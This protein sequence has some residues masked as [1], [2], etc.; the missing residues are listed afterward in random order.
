MKGATIAPS[1][2]ETLDIL[3]NRLKIFSARW[4]PSGFRRCPLAWAIANAAQPTD[5]HL[6]STG[7]GTVAMLALCLPKPHRCWGGSLCQRCLAQRNIIL[8][9]PVSH[10]RCSGATYE[11]PPFSL[12]RTIPS[13]RCAHLPRKRHSTS[14]AQRAAGRFESGGR[15]SLLRDGCAKY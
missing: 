11:I 13:I 3:S 15:R 1:E 14:D 10:L 4:P 9:E 8:N 7:K 6:T 5:R 12:S 2:D